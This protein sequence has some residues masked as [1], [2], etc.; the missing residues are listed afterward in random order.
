MRYFYV[1]YV[2]IAL[3]IFY[4]F[5]LPLAEPIMFAMPC[6]T[7]AIWSIVFIDCNLTIKNITQKAYSEAAHPN[8]YTS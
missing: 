3:V 2:F 4:M 8:S 7:F 6:I 5:I 1:V